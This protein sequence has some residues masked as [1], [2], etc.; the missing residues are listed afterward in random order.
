MK[1]LREPFFLL[2]LSMLLAGLVYLG[3]QPPKALPAN[4]AQN[5][6]SADRALSKL[7]ILYPDNLPHPAG[8]E[9]NLSLR[10]RLVEQFQDLGL[11]TE[12]QSLIHCSPAL[13][14]C[15]PVHNIMARLPGSG[16]S[17]ALLLLAHY[18]SVPAGPGIGDDAAGVTAILEIAAMAVKQGG[19]NHDL[20]FLLT[21]AEEVGLLGADAFATQHPWFSDVGLVINLEGRGASGPSN[22]FET[23][24]GNRSFIRML[25]QSLDRPVANSLSRE[26]Y[27]RMPNDT[28]FSIFRDLGISGFNFAFTGGAA[29]Y[30][31]AIDDAQQLDAD[32]L[33]HHGQ[34]AWALLQVVDQRELQR[35]NAT[36]DAVYVDLLGQKLLHYPASSATGLAL[37]LSVLLLVLIRLVFPRQISLRQVLWCLLFIV[38]LLPLMGGLG[39]LL[40]W[41]LGHWPDLN[42]M[43]HPYPWLGRVCLFFTAALALRLLLT[44]LSHR[45]T[46]GSVSLA[47]WLVFAAMAMILSARLPAASFLGVLPMVGFVLGAVIDGILWKRHTRLLFARLFGFIG[48]AYLGFYFLFNLEV[49]LSLEHAHFLIAPLVLPAI[50]MLPLL[51]EN[52]GRHNSAHWATL[53]LLVPI[54]AACIGQQFLPGHT[55]DRPRGMSLVYRATEGQER[56]FWQ[57]ETSASE[58]D[59]HFAEQQGYV[60]QTLDL[61]GRGSVELLA[62][63]ASPIELPA[64][65][66]LSSSQQIDGQSLRQVLQLELPAGLQ[67]LALFLPENLDFTSV[68]VA[69]VLALQAPG[70]ATTAAKGQVA[71][72]RVASNGVAK[73]WGVKRRAVS[74]NRPVAGS[75]LVEISSPVRQGDSNSALNLGIRA[76]HD[77][78]EEALQTE[79]VGWPI[80]A[81]PLQYGHR[82]ELEYQFIIEK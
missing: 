53:L 54:L 1:L 82:A 77:V 9:Q 19:F 11:L 44:G 78:P 74:I 55:L 8:S 36:E 52:S 41:P 64:V 72:N 67:Q 21:D 79:L 23:G 24:A 31:S 30:H 5:E 61:L 46:T 18:D 6:F 59:K 33:Q 40:S 58:A 26:V 75:L 60:W 20:I 22:M 49:V 16:R 27:R 50:A 38:L 43:G 68:H 3:L 29:V 7:R 66:L 12:V 57:L 37:V 51:A 28:D 71:K 14:L 45:A 2:L 39:W 76:R 81:Q 70:S 35:I 34:N 65:R 62:K 63:P 10:D 32:S 13:G 4:A 15:S 17:Q 69:G 48:A 80:D 42:L 73:N 25:A 56:A 47:C